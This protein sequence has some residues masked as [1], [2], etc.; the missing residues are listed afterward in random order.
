MQE[1]YVMSSYLVDLED[2]IERPT[3]AVLKQGGWFFGQLGTYTLANPLNVSSGVK[4]K[5]PFPPSQFSYS[6]SKNFTLNYD[7][8]TDK[9]HPLDV[10]DCF[11][12]NLRFKLKASSQS[13]YLDVL[14]E[15]PSVSF[16]PIL[17]KTLS[18]SKQAGDE[19]FQGITELLYISQDVSTNGLEIFVKPNN[20]NVQIYD[21]S[22][23]IST[24]YSNT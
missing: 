18:F 20:T 8:V 11:I 6:E 19:Q 7:T 24:Q 12:V 21:L 22:L 2:N 3:R 1:E 23:L 13:G 16:N 4:T 14:V 5:I 15:S 9:F 10:G 17:A